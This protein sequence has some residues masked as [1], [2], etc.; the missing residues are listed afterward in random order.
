MCC[1]RK[2]TSYVTY[3]SKISNYMFFLY[4]YIILIYYMLLAIFF[5]LDFY[6]LLTLFIH[7]IITGEYPGVIK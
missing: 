7:V 3:V 6:F 1:E 5:L 4:L 2:N